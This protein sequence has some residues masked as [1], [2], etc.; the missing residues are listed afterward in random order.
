MVRDGLIAWVTIRRPHKGNSIDVPVAEGIAAALDAVEREADIWVAVLQGEGSRFFCTGA[1]LESAAQTGS[2]VLSIGDSGLC[3]FVR[4]RRSKP[5]IA[6]VNGLAL[7]GGLEL[8]LSCDLIIASSH[9]ELGLPEVSRGLVAGSGGVVRLGR[10]LPYHVAV[11][12]AVLGSRISA[13]RAHQ[14]GLVNRLATA[15]TLHE[16]VRGVATNLCDNAPL[17]VRE[18]LTLMRE[19]DLAGEDESWLRCAEASRRLRHTE[20][21]LEGVRA[22][23]EHRR[24]NWQGR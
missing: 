7:A 15:E 10:R 6:A 8:A 16:V 20:D 5:W 2:R 12:L 14:L 17:A 1:D 22:F 11:E 21:Y 13:V 9:A 4:A 19:I 3:G 18:A 24:P 23:L